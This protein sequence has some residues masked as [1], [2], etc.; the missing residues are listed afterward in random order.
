MA[1]TPFIAL[2]TL[3][4]AA[5]A[6]AYDWDLQ[7]DTVGQGYQVRR[8]SGDG[9]TE[10]LSRRRLTQ[11]V[12][13]GVYNLLPEEWTED[14][15]KNQIYV[16]TRLRFETDFGDYPKLSARQDIPE[17][18]RYAFT[19]LYGYVG[20]RDLFGH[21]DFQLGRQI[22]IDL[23]DFYSFDGLLVRVRAPRYLA[24]EVMG[25]A[26]VRAE[27]PLASPIFELDG[28]SRHARDPQ[29]RPQQE[30][31]PAGTY[32]VALETWGLRNL[33]SRLAYRATLSPT[34]GREAD[35][36]AAAPIQERL[37]WQL[38]GRLLDGKLQPAVGL[39]YDFMNM[40][41]DE[42]EAAL[43]VPA[44]RHHALVAEYLRSAPI[45][46]GDSI[47]NVFANAPYQ[48]V[49]VGWDFTAAGVSGYARGFVRLFQDGGTAWDLGGAAG[50]QLAVAGGRGRVRCDA[51]YEGGYAG[52]HTG[53]DARTRWDLVRGWLAADG[54]V[55]VV[56]TAPPA[57]TPDRIG[58]VAPIT[59]L[60]LEGG[61]RWTPSRD[62]VL[63]LLVE[64]NLSGVERELR[65]FGQLEL[66][67][68][69]FPTFRKG[70]R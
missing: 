5:P 4:V 3:L 2:A 6:A 24:V 1:R 68:W 15:K 35:E 32:G 46:D 17:L 29:A 33:Y 59:S 48:D 70:Q 13:L 31:A 42:I 7:A 66:Y 43:R 38:Q 30:D 51:Y 64:T 23:M 67:A 69:L 19:L 26:E 40:R 41:F 28:T 65:V 57:A 56:S 10:M 44:W 47:F 45:F 16:V 9:G 50:A 39:R 61:L 21:V 60:G 14:G 53:L 52:R 11:S 25:G 12:G 55:T 18:Q 36:P 8:F 49:R 27:W 62:L 37:A 58:N 20:G 54:R 63:N 34:R 22:T